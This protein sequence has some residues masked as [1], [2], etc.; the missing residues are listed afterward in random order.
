MGIAV[1]EATLPL[2]VCESV[3]KGEFRGI[4]PVCILGCS[5]WAEQQKAGSFLWQWVGGLQDILASVENLFP[6]RQ[7][8]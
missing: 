2:S 7:S 3:R 4:T 6:V 8:T 1:A 5:V